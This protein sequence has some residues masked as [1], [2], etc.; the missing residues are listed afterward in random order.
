MVAPSD[1]VSRHDRA[2]HLAH[3]AQKGLSTASRTTASK[4]TAVIWL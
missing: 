2:G 1:R 3:T 4:S